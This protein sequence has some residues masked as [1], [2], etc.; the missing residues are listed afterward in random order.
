M[1]QT[2]H[3]DGLS[4]RAT[5][6]VLRR[7]WLVAIFC[8]LAV[9]ALAYGL[10]RLQEEE[11]TAT[12]SLL[13]RDPG[14][15]QKLFGS[16]FVAP[17]QDPTR[18]AATNATLVSLKEVARRTAEALNGALTVDQVAAAVQAEGEGQAD[19]V[20]VKATDPSPAFAARL[21]N[22]FVEQYIQFRRE[23]DRSKIREA[24]ELVAR[25]LQR[26]P[27]EEQ[28]GPQAQSLREREQQLQILTSLQ[29][30]NAELV[31][32]AEIP[33]SPSSPKTL[34]NTIIGAFF[35]LV[36]AIVLPFFLERLDRRV[37]DPRELEDR[38]ER[39]IL[40]AIPHSRALHKNG[41]AGAPLL[42][43]REI[44]AF[45]MLRANL[46][47]FNVDRS[48]RSVLITSAA[49]GDG[50]STVTWNLASA[51]ANAGARALVIEADLRHPS[52]GGSNNGVGP[53]PGLSNVLAGERSLAEAVQEVPLPNRFSP[54]PPYRSDRP[55]RTMDV[56]TAGAIPPNPGD[57]LE[58]DRMHQVIE[59]AISR[60]DLVIVD[61]PPTSVV[62]DAV[63][64]VGEVDGVIVVARLGKTDRE[65][66]VHL[67]N[68]LT[69]LGAPV[70]GIVVNGVRS[71]RTYGYGYGYDPKP[72]AVNGPPPRAR[73]DAP[74][75]ASAPAV[76][77]AEPRQ[78]F[79][80]RR[81]SRS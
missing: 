55:V 51:V 12:A 37:R 4:L 36:L 48:T 25:Q 22:S 34:R 69:N 10:S 58:S 54:D 40:G 73:E 47:Y 5:L 7:H 46:R 9:P 52:L 39:P 60:Y 24:Q 23:A 70:L 42:P 35:G 26:L 75:E 49:P 50:K 27:D 68:Q 32:R 57:L 21:A 1:H 3:F 29:T 2:Q 19:V 78:R 65:A 53:N 38:F 72:P 79:G 71:S 33:T 64:L 76:S 28:E 15:D 66:I 74:I 30:G 18:A 8:L 77:V 11:Y 45:S 16:D 31:Q 62:S 63:P 20:S 81:R 14:L 6:A 80:L 44:E 17:A 67:R 56:V 41:P 61:T 43:S 13:F 59:E